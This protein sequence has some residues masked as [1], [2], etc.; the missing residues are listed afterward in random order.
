M[1]KFYTKDEITKLYGKT[2]AT[3]CDDSLIPKS[4]EIY[5]KYLESM[6]SIV[7][8]KGRIEMPVLLIK[9]LLSKPDLYKHLLNNL[10]SMDGYPIKL[11]YIDQG[12]IEDVYKISRSDLV[13]ALR[14]MD[15]S[16]LSIPEQINITSICSLSTTKSC[17]LKYNNYVH[18]CLIDGTMYTIDAKI[19][20]NLLTE[21]DNE[22]NIFLTVDSN[23]KYEKKYILYMLRDFVERERIFNKYIFDHQVYERYENIINF[24]YIDFESLNKNQKS[25]DYDGNGESIVEKLHIDEDFIKDIQKYAKKTYNPLERAIHAYI[26]MCEL[27]TYDEQVFID[28]K[29]AGKHIDPEH[30]ASINSDNNKVICYEFAFIFAYI[31]KKLDIN[32]TMNAKSFMDS[33]GYA[34]VEFRFQEYLIKADAIKNVIDSDLTNIKVGDK[35]NG[36]TCLNENVAT[37]KKFNELSNKIRFNILTRKNELET[38]DRNVKNIRSNLRLK[39]LSKKEKIKIL[40][41]VITRDNLKGLDKL[42]YQRKI[43]ESIFDDEDNIKMTFISNTNNPFTIISSFENDTY[44]YYAVNE[45]VDS[46]LRVITKEELLSKIDKGEYVLLDNE[47]IPG[48]IEDKGVSYAK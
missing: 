22:F 1:D 46:P 47:N 3:M 24:K 2:Y 6:V 39:D 38:Y 36:L 26:R 35:L 7:T 31:L 43:F 5:S 25:D 37:Q 21:S 19:L 32:Y 4:F 14:S 18:K 8:P 12:K 42:I 17:E 20:L 33:P 23:S 30:I 44:R 10:D 11:K 48:L 45:T 28:Y 34:T 40:L 16:K 41:K 27:L 29:K 15:T 9:D 13:F